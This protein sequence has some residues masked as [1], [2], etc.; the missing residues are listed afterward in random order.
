MA[1]EMKYDK[2]SKASLPSM[3]MDTGNK[4]KKKPA[5]DIEK[6]YQYDVMGPEDDGI[7]KYHNAYETTHDKQDFYDDKEE[8]AF[9]IKKS[10]LFPK[11]KK[12]LE[13]K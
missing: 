4:A 9:R 6:K 3:G 11:I 8:E 10:A 5:Q 7:K 12:A 2:Y 1:K 13:K